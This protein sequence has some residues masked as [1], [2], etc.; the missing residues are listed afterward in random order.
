MDETQKKRQSDPDSHNRRVGMR[1]G[2]RF[3]AFKLMQCFVQ[4]AREYA[5][6]KLLPQIGKIK[7]VDSKGARLTVT[8]V[9]AD[10]L[11]EAVDTDYI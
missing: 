6:L 10:T 11:G 4:E 1:Y 3:T 5:P 9:D 7:M 8:C 2:Y